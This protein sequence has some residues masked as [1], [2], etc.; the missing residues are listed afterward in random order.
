MGGVKLGVPGPMPGT[1]A[2][3]FDGK[4]GRVKLGRMNGIHSVE[5]WT[6]TRTTKD[7]VAFSNRNKNHEFV[8]F[9]AVGGMAHTQDSYPIF[10]RTVCNGQWHH[11]VYTYDTAT[12]TG[13]IYVD[14]KLSQLAVWQRL[15]GGADAS[16]AF[17]A[18]LSP[19]SAARSPRWRSTRTSCRRRRSRATTRRPGGAWRRTRRWGSCARS[20]SVR[21]P[22]PSR[23][24]SS[25][26]AT[27]S[28]CPSAKAGTSNRAPGRRGLTRSSPGNSK[29]SGPWPGSS[30][31]LALTGSC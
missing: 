20:R 27:A 10:A 11:L 31:W 22:R 17:D 3:S 16:I 12:S 23:S 30:P 4:T 28:S 1:T 9:G 24:L 14:G 7:A 29:T 19:T 5:L 15:E 18:S 13:K 21:T 26:H 8:A 25:A 6:K 2:A